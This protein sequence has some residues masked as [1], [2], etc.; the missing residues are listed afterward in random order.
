MNRR[1]FLNRLCAGIAAC[2]I[3][4]HDLR[5]GVEVKP[6]VV[7]YEEFH[8]AMMKHLLDEIRRDGEAF[9]SLFPSIEEITFT[10]RNWQTVIKR[11]DPPPC[12]SQS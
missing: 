3:P 6:H 4:I 5:F 1:S 7:T 10:P 11:I 9:A 8:A 12:D 2:V